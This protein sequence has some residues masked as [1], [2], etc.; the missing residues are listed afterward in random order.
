MYDC[1]PLY[2]SVGGVVAVGSVLAAGG[3][4]VIAPNFSA[5]R[6]WD[7]VAGWGCTLFQ[8]IGELCRYLVNAPP[9][10]LE[11]SHNLRIACGNGLRADIWEKFRHR[12]H[13][14][15]VVEFYAAT[16]GNFSLYNA[17]GETG[18]IGRI[19]PFLSHRFPVAIVKHD[20]VSLAPHREADGRCVRVEPGEPGEAIGRIGAGTRFEGYTTAEESERKV[21]RNVFEEGDA[22]YRTGDLM[23]SDARGFYYFIDRIGDTFRW[24][25]E[26]V[27]TTEIANILSQCEGV[28]DAIVYGVEVSGA[29]GRAG[30]ALLVPR[31]GFDL[32]AFRKYARRRLPPYALP[33]FLRLAS[34]VQTT[35][36]FKYRKDQL[37]RDSFNPDLTTDP[38]FVGDPVA[39]E[40]FNIDGE[41]YRRICSGKARL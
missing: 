39:N 40:Y 19:P 41:V 1:L 15:Q 26:N 8:Y 33:V 13:I 37:V 11:T 36:T 16:E 5:R 29:D 6:F 35:G 22:W 2:H 4:V 14:P 38:M 27:S 30:M 31:G 23:R 21:L 3:S 34:S 28:S 9:H 10:P 24:K 32:G 18:A 12:F 20:Y 25:G 7:D 17:E